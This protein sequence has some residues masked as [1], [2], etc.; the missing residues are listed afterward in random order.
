MAAKIYDVVIVGGGLVGCSFALDLIVNDHNLNV[1]LIEQVQPDFSTLANLDSRIYA[2]SPRNINH[3]SDLAVAYDSSRI[4]KIECME[5]YGNK[6]SQ[7]FFDALDTSEK[8]LAKIVECKNLHAALFF[9]LSQFGNLDFSYGKVKDVGTDNNRA[10]IKLANDEIIHANLLVAA[11]GGNSFVRRKMK[12]ETRQ[13]DYYQSGVVANF[14][15]GKN[16][17]NKAYQWFFGDSILALLPLPNQQISIVWSTNQPELLLQSSEEELC[18]MVADASGNVLGRLSLVTRPQAFPLKLNMIEKCF[19]GHIV[20]IGDAFHTIHPLA[21]QG[22]NLGFGDAWQLSQL[23]RQVGVTNLNS[24]ELSRFNYSRLIEVRKMQMT[25][26][27]LQRLFNNRNVI[28]DL[29]RNTGLNMINSVAPLKKLLISSA[30]N[31]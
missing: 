23:I 3:L 29:L 22:V 6:N 20:L 27:T 25:C 31:Y 13:I 9:R 30:I 2:I 7:I 1:L 16:H 10:W 24:I 19:K 8:Y 11:D 14:K 21:G 12:M 26:H 5:I 4:G 18:R 28:V 15:C 17:Q